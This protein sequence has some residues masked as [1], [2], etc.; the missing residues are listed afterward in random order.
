MNE[1]VIFESQFKDS[2]WTDPVWTNW[3]IKDSYNDDALDCSYDGKIY[4]SQ[5]LKFGKKKNY[6]YRYQL[7]RFPPDIK[8]KKK[9]ETFSFCYSDTAKYNFV[10]PFAVSQ[11]EILFSSDMPGG[12]GGYDLWKSVYDEQ[13]KSWSKPENLGPDINS[14]DNEQFPYV[15]TDG[16]L[17]FASDR[18]EGM[19]GYDIYRAAQTAAGKWSNPENMKYPVNSPAEDWGIIFEGEKEKG[20]FISNRQGGKGGFDIYSFELLPK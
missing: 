5:E 16:S 1:A 10:T 20:F 4:L 19:G 12:F 8:D 11:K 13:S 3:S 15:R 7:A 14:Y 17:Y 9:V 2:R 6:F 18:I